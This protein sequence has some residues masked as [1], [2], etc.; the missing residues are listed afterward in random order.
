MLLHL[1]GRE[2]ILQ[3]RPEDIGLDRITVVVVTDPPLLFHIP[4]SANFQNALKLI[5]L[6]IKEQRDIIEEIEFV[7]ACKISKQ[8]NYVGFVPTQ[9]R[10]TRIANACRAQGWTAAVDEMMFYYRIQVNKLPQ[11]EEQTTTLARF[12]QDGL[13][14]FAYY[15]NVDEASKNVVRVKCVMRGLVVII[16]ITRE[17]LWDQ[18]YIKKGMFADLRTEYQRK[19]A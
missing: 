18:N 6:S 16:R 13:T 10:A 4:L 17:M 14:A 9:D 11:A 19:Y 1:D 15:Q 2:V 7:N 5:R 8:S 3:I 12:D